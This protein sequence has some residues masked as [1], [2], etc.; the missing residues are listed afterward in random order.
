MKTRIAVPI[1]TSCLTAALATALFA[2][3]G[4]GSAGG[5]P[6]AARQGME[7][8][9]QRL[10]NQPFM[11]TREELAQSVGADKLEIF[12]DGAVVS[13][14]LSPEGTYE[15]LAMEGGDIVGFTLGD[16]RIQLGADAE[17]ADRDGWWAKHGEY[18]V[19][20]SKKPQA[21][22]LS[23]KAGPNEIAVECA[24]AFKKS[25]ESVTYYVGPLDGL[26]CLGLGEEAAG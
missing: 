8:A 9:M 4:G 16:Q 22:T 13:L 18:K 15:A 14:T 19:P 26:F 25:E 20:K 1:L 11:T 6:P 5:L 21:V 10:E 17:E 3:G 23:V 7:S 2:Q 24:N 12:L